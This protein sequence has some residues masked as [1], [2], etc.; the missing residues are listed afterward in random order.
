MCVL[1]MLTIRTKNKDSNKIHM[2]KKIT[3][4]LNI[5]YKTYKN[6][7]SLLVTAEKVA[8]RYSIAFKKKYLV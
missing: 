2:N 4:N 7:I 6:W 1:E 5:G 8:V 3:F